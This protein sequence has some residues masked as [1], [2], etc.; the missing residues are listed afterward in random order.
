MPTCAF[1]RKSVFPF[2]VLFLGISFGCNAQTA[3]E[4][5][6]TEQL[7]NYQQ[8][9]QVDFLRQ[10]LSV[11]AHD[12]LQGRET[13]TAGQKI[14]G[15]YLARQYEAMGLQPMGDNNSYFQNF[16]LSAVQRDSTVFKLYEGNQLVDRSVESS[17]TTG[18]FIRAFGGADSL[19]GDIIFGGFGVNDPDHGVMHLGDANLEGKWVLIFQDIPYVV[20][21]D[22][23]IDTAYNGSERF[24]TILK[25]GAE[26]VL[27]IAPM[28]ENEFEASARQMARLSYSEPQRLN[29]TY[30]NESTATE[31]PQGYNTIKPS[32]AAQMLGLSGGPES[33][34][35]YRQE[36]IQNITEFR[37]ESTDYSLT[38]L[39]YT[40]RKTIGSENVVAMLEGSDPQLKDEVVVLTAHYDHVGI[41]QPD[42]TG[43]AIYN[44][45][46][47]DGSG[48]VALLNMAKAYTQ[49]KEDGYTPRRSIL[50]L[51]VSG[52]EIGL[53][54]SRYYS[55]HPV[56]PMDKT[57][58]NINI[59]M[60]GRIDSVHKQQDISEYSYIIGSELISSEL[61][62]LLKVANDRS[63]QIELDKGYNDLKDPNQFYRRSDHWNFGRFRVP[64][65]FFFTG[66]HEDYHRPSDEIHKI[67][68]SK[69][70]EI[71]RT[72]YATSVVV[73]NEEKPPAVD[74]EAFI[75][76]TKS[77]M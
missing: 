52:E 67:R 6:R 61:D 7:L 44:G 73:A 74:N 10:H 40:S 42:S 28:Q 51:H 2:L 16:E 41:G 62:S 11:L 65:I 15:R 30:L 13:G 37:P 22:T 23:L 34:E 57:V 58:A 56:I 68:F 76:I 60:I 14:A 70:A 9:I 25:S 64:F 26:G 59:D 36:L 5:N 46:D 4:E 38:H 20:D 45:A 77:G 39:P 18:N 17:D 72:I 31:L 32:L 24:R 19:S 12:S 63:G 1:S 53:M 75:D 50:F 47:D 8:Q 54:G 71:I 21:G 69:M 27:I 48:T 3:V 49:A 55:D 35:Q 66:V 29:L 33:L 43:D